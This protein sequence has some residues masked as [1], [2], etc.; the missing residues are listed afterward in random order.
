MMMTSILVVVALI[1]LNAILI[2]LLRIKG[3]LQRTPFW[4]ED[5]IALGLEGGPCFLLRGH[6]GLPQVARLVCLVRILDLICVG[7]CRCLGFGSSGCITLGL[8]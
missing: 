3:P 1:V 5:L 4:N 2:L 6:L 8:P 7:G